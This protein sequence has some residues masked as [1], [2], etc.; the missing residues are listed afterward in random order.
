MGLVQ[1][2]RRRG[3]PVAFIP[4]LLMGKELTPQKLASRA[5]QMFY[6]D[7]ADYDNLE[8]FHSEILSIF[9]IA[10]SAFPGR[11]FEAPS[12]E[13]VEKAFTE[14]KS[15][16]DV[17]KEKIFMELLKNTK[18]GEIDNITL[19]VG[20]ATPPFS[21]VAKR[22]GENVTPFKMIKNVPDA[23][24]V[25]TVTLLMLF[26]VKLIRKATEKYGEEAE[27]KEKKREE[28]RKEERRKRR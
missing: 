15:S 16:S 27:Y 28:K 24:F 14:W 13:K 20:L 8:A 4:L 19:I 18:P 9:E 12:R 5:I 23:L 22:A 21:M 7:P 25:P 3:S 17:E 26:S 11:H 6:S 10:N 1:S 2:I